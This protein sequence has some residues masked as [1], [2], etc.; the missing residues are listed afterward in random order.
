[1]DCSSPLKHPCQG[2]PLLHDG[3]PQDRWHL[4]DQGG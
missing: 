3:P 1:M 4:T 2:S